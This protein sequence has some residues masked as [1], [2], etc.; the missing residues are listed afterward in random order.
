MKIEKPRIR[1]FKTE[2]GISIRID[3]NLFDDRKDA[4]GHL[5]GIYQFN[6][7]DAIEIIDRIIEKEAK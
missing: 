1:A 7:K 3:N 6:W 4:I 5:M 2:K